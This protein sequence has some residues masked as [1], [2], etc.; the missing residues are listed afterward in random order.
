MI[1]SIVN[2][3]VLSLSILA[4]HAFPQAKEPRD[5]KPI[6]LRLEDISDLN[7]KLPPGDYA[8]NIIAYCTNYSIHRPGQGVPYTLAPAEG[9]KI[10]AIANLTLQGEFAH[11]DR[12]TL[13]NISSTIQTGL[14][15]SEWRPEYKTV[16]HQ[17]IPDFEGDLRGDLIDEYRGEYERVRHTIPVSLP[18]F[19]TAVSKLPLGKQLLTIKKARAVLTDRSISAQEV[20]DRLYQ[21][22][23][24]GTPQTLTPS[25][26]KLSPWVKVK[27]NVMA[28]ATVI[29]GRAGDGSSGINRL[30]FRI[31]GRKQGNKELANKQPVKLAGAA[32]KLPET[33]PETPI[34]VFRPVLIEGGAGAATV[35]ESLTIG[36]I[37]YGAAAVG[38]GIGVGL[39][40]G[41]L[42]L[43][44]VEYAVQALTVTP[45]IEKEK[46]NNKK[47]LPCKPVPFGGLA[48]EYHS[49][50]NGNKPHNE[51]LEHTHHFKMNQSPPS[52]GCICSWN[53]NFINPTPGFSPLPGAVP[54]E[55]ASGGGVAS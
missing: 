45:E 36:E 28:R 18:N 49:T 21:A 52:R 23:G 40:V 30:E 9:T 16:A 39:I 15:L 20:G 46:E 54:V 47:C 25:H 12:G 27:E 32:L 55:P 8:M 17:L 26:P 33:L 24:D 1:N 22:T 53:R 38:T 10:K 43:Y 34:P 13:Q 7:A 4:H 11:V 48:Y 50:A 44:G 37:L 6:S 3:S 42:I 2:F 35:A 14:P 41:S 31:L 51:M 19:D 5:F 29:N